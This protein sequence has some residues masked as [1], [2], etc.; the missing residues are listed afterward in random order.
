MTDT[1]F[2]TRRRFLLGA[3]AFLAVPAIV[4]VSS[5][6]PISVLQIAPPTGV[7]M[8]FQGS[9]LYIGPPQYVVLTYGT[10][11]ST[12]FRDMFQW[13]RLNDWPLTPPA[14]QTTR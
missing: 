12:Q 1:A 9:Q 2:R 14:A 5:I 3:G 7:M 8:Y 4:R 11:S 10:P 6:M 13:A